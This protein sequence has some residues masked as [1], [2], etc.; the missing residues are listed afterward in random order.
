MDRQ[1]K[2]A[3]AAVVGFGVVLLVAAVVEPQRAPL[4]PQ[5]TPVTE[6]QFWQKLQSLGY[7][8]VKIERDRTYLK[9]AAMKDGRHESIAVDGTDG[10]DV[11]VVVNDVD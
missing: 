9:A 4:F 11:S 2:S 6:E 8:D 7:S 10:E 1:A 3:A 5:G